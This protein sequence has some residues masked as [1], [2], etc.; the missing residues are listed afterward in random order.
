M[1]M[2]NPAHPGVL[3]AE[4]SLP[5]LGISGRDLAIHLSYPEDLLLEVLQARSRLDADLAV[6][7]EQAGI[8][9]AYTWLAMQMSYDLWQAQHRLQP[10]IQR[11]VSDS[12]SD[13]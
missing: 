13:C 10:T 3:L 5:A 8:G 9:T 2:H 12:H 7:L 1:N 6:R 11:L 4:D